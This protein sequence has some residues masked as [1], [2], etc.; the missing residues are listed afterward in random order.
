VDRSRYRTDN[1]LLVQ[2]IGDSRVRQQVSAH[3]LLFFL[4]KMKLVGPME[5]ETGRPHPEVKARELHQL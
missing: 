4:A 5:G 1:E 3:A 2:H